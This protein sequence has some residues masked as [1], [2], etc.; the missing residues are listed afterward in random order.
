MKRGRRERHSENERKERSERDGLLE[1]P[2]PQTP[3]A[4]S[5]QGR[6]P[7]PEFPLPFSLRGTNSHFTSEKTE[8]Q[9]G[10]IFVFFPSLGKNLLE[11]E[12]FQENI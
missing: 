3:Q 5:A 7:Q 12:G 8:A 4:R 10:Q 2:S 6:T 11:R 1:P 9:R